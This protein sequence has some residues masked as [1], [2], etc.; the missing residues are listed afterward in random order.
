VQGLKGVQGTQGFR[1][2]KGAWDERF[3][4]VTGT[5][6]VKGT[7]LGAWGAGGAGV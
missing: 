2:C 5:Q 4:G 6:E 1:W 3:A 7:L